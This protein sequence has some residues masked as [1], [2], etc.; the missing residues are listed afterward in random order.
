MSRPTQQLLHPNGIKTKKFIL[1]LLHFLSGNDKPFAESVK[2][3]LASGDIPD[4]ASWQMVIDSFRNTAIR[5][6]DNPFSRGTKC[7]RSEFIHCISGF[8]RICEAR[9]VFPRAVLKGIRNAH[10][11]KRRRKILGDLPSHKLSEREIDRLVG[12]YLRQSVNKHDI[13][14]EER[15]AC[16]RTLASSGLSIAGMTD[17]Q[18]IEEIRKLNTE[19]LAEVRRCAEADFI[20]GWEAYQEGQQLLAESDLSYEVDMLGPMKE[21]FEVVQHDPS[22]IRTKTVQNPFR[23]MFLGTSKRINGRWTRQ[24]LPVRVAKSRLLTLLDGRYGLCPKLRRSDKDICEE[25]ILRIWR[26]VFRGNGFHDFEGWPKE[27]LGTSMYTLLMAQIILLIDTGLNV[28][29][30]DGLTVDCVRDTDVPTIKEIWGIKSRADNKPVHSRVRIDSKDR[31]NSIVVIQ[32]VK[33]MTQ[34]LR[35]LAKNGHPLYE[36]RTEEA[37]VEQRLFL[38]EKIIGVPMGSVTVT[39]G[40]VAVYDKALKKFKE[41]HPSIGAYSFL[42]TSI[43]PTVR[44]LAFVNGE[45]IETS[46]A[47]LAHKTIATSTGYVVRTLS[48]MEMEERIRGFMKHYEAIVIQDIEDAARRLGYTTA[49]YEDRLANAK[50]TGL[51]TICD[52]QRKDDEGKEFSVKRSDC[53]PVDD[54]PKCPLA[55]VFPAL[56]ENLV[57]AFM[58]RRWIRDNEIELRM[59]E[60]R[61]QEV[62]MRWLA[63]VEGGIDKAKSA[64]NVSRKILREAEEMAKALGTADFVPLI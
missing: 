7:S 38:R 26:N 45:D 48:R 47:Q 25:P 29:V 54:C 53:D 19:R 40:V 52:H 64:H 41:N 32:R 63:I 13:I 56:K 59:N 57:D 6:K 50:R 33:E 2:Q 9:G 18:I 61:W 43:R 23:Q 46:R 44:V 62:W 60:E 24:P 12:G 37:R 14:E 35:R 15:K 11:H 27:R 17:G 3:S 58:M 36:V 51:G 8:L 1:W 10:L 20:K 30:V 49:E 4:Q 55:R 21:W 31:A 28:E 34:R 42:P 39:A 16:I 5:N 22:G